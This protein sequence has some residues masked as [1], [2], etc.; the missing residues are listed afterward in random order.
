M[1]PN[2]PEPYTLTA[3]DLMDLRLRMN[4][5]GGFISDGV[6]GVL[7]QAP[8]VTYI[9][10]DHAYAL[11]SGGFT[12]AI[13]PKDEVACWLLRNER[14]EPGFV[15]RILDPALPIDVALEPPEER[16][17]YQRQQNANAATARAQAAEDDAEARRRRTQL[18][19]L[20]AS[21]LTIEDLFS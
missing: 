8:W 2:E 16:R 1:P 18:K 4:R 19:P 15:R 10:T 3:P 6:G 14:I 5:T 11:H 13:T 20:D 12:V 17:A 21:S 9:M 7:A